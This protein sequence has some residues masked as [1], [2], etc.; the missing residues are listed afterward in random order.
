MNR[1]IIILFLLSSIV[2]ASIQPTHIDAKIEPRQIN[3]GDPIEMILTV[4]VPSST[5]INWPTE[6][7]LTPASILDSEPFLAG[8][9]EQSYRYS[10]SVYELGE[11]ELPEIPLIL[12]ESDQDTVADTVW[13]DLGTVEVVSLL[14]DSTID[15][16]DIRPP[17]KLAWLF[18]DFLPYILIAIGIGVALFLLYRWQTKWKKGAEP[19]YSWQEEPPDP[20]DLALKRL[21]VLHQEW[22]S[23]N[24]SNE[25]YHSELSDILKV[26]L[27]GKY[28]F[29][30]AALTTNELFMHRELWEAVDSEN[31]EKL[32]QILDTTDKIRFAGIEKSDNEQL[33]ESSRNFVRDTGKAITLDDNSKE[34]ANDVSR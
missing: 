16:H 18:S 10:I 9:S 5:K 26:Y 25:E 28:A 27:G 34:G 29:Q 32:N 7:H 2:S 31:A 14:G 12:F 6:E 20:D 17:I 4:G 1:T 24:L 3:I 21:R 33:L 23:G 22:E 30:A 13:I 19:D 8:E 11:V 15:I